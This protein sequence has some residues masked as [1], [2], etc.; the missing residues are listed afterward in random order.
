MAITREN[1]KPQDIE[2]T[3]AQVA[4]ACGVSVAAIYNWIDVDLFRNK[5]GK[6]M[7]SEIGEWIRKVQVTKNGKGRGNSY[8][9]APE[10]WGPLVAPG[11]ELDDALAPKT[12]DRIEMRLKEAQAIKVEMEN[13]VRAGTLVPVEETVSAWRTIL[14]RVRTRLLKLPTTLAPLVLD[15]PDVLSIQVK[16]KTAV[17]D[18]LSEASEDWREERKDQDDE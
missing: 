4:A 11:S 17:D 3:T 10:G 5:D 14:S 16:L 12:K 2:L 8:P 6:F 13:A 9:Y 15:D 7:L 1:D 18:A